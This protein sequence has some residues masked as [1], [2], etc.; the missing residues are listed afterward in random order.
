MNE[1]E[2]HQTAP[3]MTP[4]YKESYN[5]YDGEVVIYDL[6]DGKHHGLANV[7]GCSTNGV[8]VLGKQ[9]IIKPLQSI[10]SEEYPFDYTV[11]FEANMRPVFPPSGKS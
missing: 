5:F 1:Y 6:K 9:Y 10:H 3:I 8:A 2:W 7:V 11:C 4:E